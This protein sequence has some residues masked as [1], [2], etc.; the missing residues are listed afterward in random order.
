MVDT[1]EEKEMFLPDA[2]VIV[3]VC[4]ELN[5]QGL[6]LTDRHIKMWRRAAAVV[7]N[8]FDSLEKEELERNA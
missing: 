5:R 3:F 8:V 2:L 7:S 1:S 4:S 6:V